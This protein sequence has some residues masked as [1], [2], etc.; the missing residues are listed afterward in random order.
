MRKGQ[1]SP[2]IASTAGYLS[3]L[4]MKALETEPAE[5]RLARV[6]RALQKRGPDKSLFELDEEE[7]G[8][9]GNGLKPNRIKKIEGALTPKEIV[10][11]S[12]QELTK[13]DT[14]DHCASWIAEEPSRAPLDRMRQQVQNSVLQH[15]EGRAKNSSDKHSYTELLCNQ[16]S[17]VLLFHHLFLQVN[18]QVVDCLRTGGFR[19]AAIGAGMQAISKLVCSGMGMFAIPEKTG[20]NAVS[21][22]RKYVRRGLIGAQE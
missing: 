21:A 3:S 5:E 11:L 1:V 7:E 16:L 9:N 22:R 2:R 15:Q 19:A 20:R 18:A 10:A 13:F 12:I 4:L 17:G 6:E 8:A 14:P